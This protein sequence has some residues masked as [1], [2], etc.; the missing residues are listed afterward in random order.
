MNEM[1]LQATS[2]AA[3]DFAGSLVDADFAA[4]YTWINLTRLTNPEPARFIAWS[5]AHGQ[6]IAIGPDCPRA[7]EAPNRTSLAQVLQS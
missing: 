7:T 3:P 1:F 5:E 2:E 6:A 4:F